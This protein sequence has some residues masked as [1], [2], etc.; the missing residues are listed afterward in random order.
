MCFF[1]GDDILR[2]LIQPVMKGLKKSF[3]TLWLLSKVILPVTFA[4]VILEYFGF[5][6]PIALFFAPFMKLLGLPGEAAIP[7]LL[8]FFINIY[9]AVGAIPTL[10]L[11]IKEITILATIIL[12]C[13]ALL[14]ESAIC[15]KA[16]LP[17]SISIS[18]RI[19]IGILVGILM[20]L[21]FIA[22]GGI[23]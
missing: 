19:G 22:T 9:A 3:A 15:K 8:G 16:G 7:L 12:I 10:E 23:V 20:N 13:H 11:G 1:K 2:V 4:V 18:L 21:F 14:V 6:E 17:W 5:I